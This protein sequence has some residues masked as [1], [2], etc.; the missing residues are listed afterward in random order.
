MVGAYCHRL[1]LACRWWLQ[2]AFDGSLMNDLE[3]VHA[4]MLRASTLKGRGALRKHTVYVPETQNKTRWT[5]YQDMAIKYTLMHSA[6]EKTEMFTG[7][8]ST[9]MEEIDVSGHEKKKRVMPLLL[10]GTGLQQFREEF[11]PCMK[12]LK[13]WF[14]GIQR[15]INLL[16]ARQ[17]FE[18]ARSSR[19]LKDHSPEFEERLLPSHKL[20]ASPHFENGVIKIMTQQTEDMS[21]EEKKACECLLKEN[22]PTLYPDRM[23]PSEDERMPDCMDSP[24]KF[25]KTLDG[26]PKK[27]GRIMDSK[28]ITTCTWI[29]PTTVAVEQLFSK[30]SNVMKC[31]RRKM[32]SHIFE[33][34]VFLKENES[35]WDLG[36]VQQM[37]SKHF[38][39]R[40]KEEYEDMEDE[41]SWEF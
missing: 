22:W 2:E 32:H 1:N 13:Q 3:A 36:L 20:V 31:D 19:R 24:T 14:G 27:T 25:L 11:I 23:D 6:L 39:D 34:I 26:S 4:V 33:A 21:P 15:N 9:D 41:D 28:Y 12:E 16:Q 5:G 7:L 38:D 8:T 17:L 37:L 29:S 30:C 40:L 10:R 35:W 18:K